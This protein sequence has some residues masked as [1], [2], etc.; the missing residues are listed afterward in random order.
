MVRDRLQEKSYFD[1]TVKFCGPVIEKRVAAF[2]GLTGPGKAG[3]SFDICDYAFRLTVSR[4]SRGD[5]LT[6]MRDGVLQIVEMLELKR[7]TLASV[8]LE[9]EVRLMYER[10]DLGTLYESLTLL[11]FMVSLRMPTADILHAIELIGHPG[12]DALLDQVARALGDTTRSVAAQS[13]FSK[14]YGALAEV[15]GLPTEDRPA[16]LKAYVDSWY[17]RMKP[18]YWHDSH[19]GAEGAYF[20]Y[21]CFE[22]ALLAMLFDID[23]NGLADHPH[24]PMDLVRNYKSGS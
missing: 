11:A 24:Y 4:Y 8:Q 12:E 2:D 3:S 17:K 9:D 19:K 7:S 13:K 22:A 6:E 21:W 20:G 5:A 10:L 14:V 18:I 15:V 16:A 23:D 1:A